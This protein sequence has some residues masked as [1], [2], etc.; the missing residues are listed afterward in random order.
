MQSACV[1]PQ[2]LE[3]LSPLLQGDDADETMSKQWRNLRLWET[4]YL[5]DPLHV[6]R[7]FSQI[8]RW[9]GLKTLVRRKMYIN[10]NFR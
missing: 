5:K 4:F 3:P 2:V 6:S 8:G 10:Y 1:I 7:S 9:W